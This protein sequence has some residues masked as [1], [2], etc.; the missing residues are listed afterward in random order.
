VANNNGTATA[1]TATPPSASPQDFVDLLVQTS[2]EVAAVVTRV[3]AEHDLSLTLVRVLGILRDRT[4]TMAELANYLG[5]ERST[6]TGLVD[7]AERRGLVIRRSSTADGRSIE[8]LL[9]VAGHSLADE[10][11]GTVSDQLTSVVEKLPPEVAAALPAV[12]AGLQE[13]RAR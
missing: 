2:F 5:L 13:A 3:G 11:A 10:V 1:T 7:R 12:F 8:L 4:L 6:V 9:S